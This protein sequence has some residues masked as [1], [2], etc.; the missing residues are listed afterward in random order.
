[1]PKTLNVRN[2]AKAALE[3]HASHRLCAQQPRA[4][5]FYINSDEPGIG[6][7]IGVAMD[8]DTAHFAQGQTTY[9]IDDII[10]DHPHLITSDDPHALRRLQYAH[11]DWASGIIT[12]ETFLTIAKELAQ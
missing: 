1:M 6:C 11:D 9:Q 5:C 4:I 7:A 2:V 10:E 8:P 3:A 12:E